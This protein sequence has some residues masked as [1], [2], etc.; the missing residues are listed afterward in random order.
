[1]KDLTLLQ[2]ANSISLAPT[3]SYMLLDCNRGGKWHILIK[4]TYFDAKTKYLT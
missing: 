4:I 2:L 1:M 3:P